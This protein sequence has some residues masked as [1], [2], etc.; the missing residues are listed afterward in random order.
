MII[1]LKNEARTSGFMPLYGHGCNTLKEM[2]DYVAF[3]AS[4]GVTAS[5]VPDDFDF[6]Q[7]CEVAPPPIDPVLK[8]NARPEGVLAVLKALAAFKR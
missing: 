4:K 6:G 7:P 5:I 2:E 3:F 1:A 8:A